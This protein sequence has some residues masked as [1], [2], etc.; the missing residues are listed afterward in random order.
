MLT[1][2]PSEDA[3]T[4]TG[5]DGNFPHPFQTTPGIMLHGADTTMPA[6]MG[7]SAFVDPLSGNIMD[8]LQLSGSDEFAW[9]MISLG[10]EEPL[11]EPVIVDEL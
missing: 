8:G 9:D 11:P 2:R 1:N 3:A 4:K 10:L 6:M 5:S 7:T